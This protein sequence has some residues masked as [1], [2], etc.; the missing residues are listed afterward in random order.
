MYHLHV[1]RTHTR[2]EFLVIRTLNCLLFSNMGSYMCSCNA[3]NMC[4]YW[5]HFLMT[6]LN[7]DL[8]YDVNVNGARESSYVAS[9][10]EH[11]TVFLRDVHPAVSESLVMTLSE[12]VSERARAA[13]LLPDPAN[14]ALYVRIVTSLPLVS[15]FYLTFPYAIIYGCCCYITKSRL[16][17]HRVRTIHVHVRQ[18]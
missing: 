4:V 1:L 16:K 6:L 14:Q 18:F 2:F 5:Q 8:L 15:Y 12:F 9:A 3:R 10:V 11:S 13:C 17:I 7:S